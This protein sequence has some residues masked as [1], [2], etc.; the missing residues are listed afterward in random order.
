MADMAG[1]TVSIEKHTLPLDV[2][3]IF[4]NSCEG[5]MVIDGQRRIVAMNPALEQLTG[6]RSQDLTDESDCA[7]LFACRDRH[8]C[9]L[10]KRPEECGGLKAI[11]QMEPV[12]GEEYTIRTVTGRRVFI[13]ASYTPVQLPGR[14]VWAL[15]VLRDAAQKRRRQ[16]LL[17]RQAMTDPLTGL[18]NRIA[19]RNAA[20]REIKRARRFLRSLAIAMADLDRFKLYNDTHGHLE[21]DQMLKTVARLLKGGRRA[22]DLVTRF[23]GDEFALLLP[24][25]DV[26]GAEVVTE[27]LRMAVAQLSCADRERLQA[28]P[29]KPVT[30]SVGVAIFPGD[31]DIWQ[32]LLGEADKRL[33]A[34]KHHGGNQVIGPE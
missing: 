31:G 3:E 14:P 18:P 13:E 16:L 20:E 32:K 29:S 15:V 8:G 25:T 27:R 19:F 9:P 10:V 22:S 7:A 1:Q 4:W 5:M 26:A 33:Y 11:L 23:G 30:L 24:D 6:Y 21:G 12:R 34:A 28:L 2:P 17:A